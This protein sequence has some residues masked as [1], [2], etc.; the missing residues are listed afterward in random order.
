MRAIKTFTFHLLRTF[1]WLIVP[2]LKLLSGLCCILLLVAMFT[3][4]PNVSGFGTVILW[5]VLSIGFGSTAWY[6]DVLIKKL[7]PIVQTNQDWS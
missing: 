2:A 6:Y 5:M 3:D 4:A 7:S 1:R